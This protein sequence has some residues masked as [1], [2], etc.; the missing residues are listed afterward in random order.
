M[1]IFKNVDG[2]ALFVS[3]TM[4]FDVTIVALASCA[5]NV[6]ENVEHYYG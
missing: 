2:K 3:F 6:S 5:E 1:H 4:L